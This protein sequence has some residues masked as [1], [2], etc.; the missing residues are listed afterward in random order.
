LKFTVPPALCVRYAC[1]CERNFYAYT[2]THWA[3]FL[4]SRISAIY[5]HTLTRTE[6]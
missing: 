4:R 1:A 5:P 6:L 3:R 2:H